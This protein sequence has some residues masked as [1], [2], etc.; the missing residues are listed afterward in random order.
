MDTDCLNDG[1]FI[2]WHSYNFHVK[3]W[4]NEKFEKFIYSTH[5]R[6]SVIDYIKD[7]F[8]NCIIKSIRRGKLSYPELHQRVLE[9]NK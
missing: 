5:D 4:N 8:P 7:Q 2:D 1:E 6:E 3:I 9:Y